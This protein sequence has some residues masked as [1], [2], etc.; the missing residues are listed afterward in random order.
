MVDA[1][2]LVA[3]REHH[4]DRVGVQAASHEREYHG[5]LLVEPVGVVHQTQQRS[6]AGTRGKQ[7]ERGQRDEEAVGRVHPFLQSEDLAERFTLWIGQLGQLG[8]MRPE[9]L[10]QRGETQLG[11]GLHGVEAHDLEITVGQ[12]L[13]VIE[14]CALA[15]PRSAPQHEDR[16][17]PVP[18][19]VEGCGQPIAFLVPPEQLNH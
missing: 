6:V 1:V 12:S 8:Q 19:G 13:N 14:Q 17:L 4:R 15:G 7:P 11:L 5:G 18:G 3:R 10:V 9:Q 2:G 16:A